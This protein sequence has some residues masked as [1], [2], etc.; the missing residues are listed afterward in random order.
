VDTKK[1]QAAG[2]VLWRP[3][4]ED[5][6]EVALIH[7]PKY[8]DWSLPKGKLNRGECHIAGAY[9]EVLDHFWAS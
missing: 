2:A 4:D 8:M 9:R 3:R 1:I 6:I 5:V 7:R